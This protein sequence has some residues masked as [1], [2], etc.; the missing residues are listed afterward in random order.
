MNLPLRTALG[1]VLAVLAI[2]VFPWPMF[3]F[4]NTFF[5]VEVNPIAWEVVVFSIALIGLGLATASLMGHR[6][7]RRVLIVL[8][9][10]MLFPMVRLFLGLDFI[11]VGFLAWPVT[12]VLAAGLLLYDLRMTRLPA[13]A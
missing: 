10:F 12:C 1:H 11:P 2:T 6:A 3:A 5:G 13:P 7:S 4:G 8:L 9:A